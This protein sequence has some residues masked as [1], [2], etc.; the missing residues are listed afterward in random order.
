MLSSTRGTCLETISCCLDSI[1][2]STLNAF[3][4]VDPVAARIVA[5]YCDL[6]ASRGGSLGV[7]HGMPIAVKDLIDVAGFATTAGSR[8]HLGSVAH[9]DATV[10][11]RL[12]AQGALIL[13]KT[14]THEFAYGSTGDNSH[15]GAV[16]N[17]HDSARISGGSSSGSA[18]AVAA[19]LCAAALGTD[20][21]ASIRIPAALCG[22]VGMKPTYGLVPLDG[23]FELSRTLDHVG[24][25]TRDVRT[26]ALMLEV[27][28]EVP[29]A[30]TQGIGR[31][32]QGLRVGR[33]H[34]FYGAHISGAVR[35]ALARGFDVLKEAGADIVDID[36]P[37]IED[38][39]N[40][41]QLILKA[42]AFAQHQKSIGEAKSYSPEVLDRLLTGRDIPAREYIEC[43]RFRSEAVAAFDRA[44]SG[45]D[46]ILTPTAG[47]V[48]PR[49]HERR[50]TVEGVELPTFQLLTRLTAPTNFSGHPSMSVPFGRNDGLPIGLQLI[51]R[52]MGEA[53]LYQI[54]SR[55]ETAC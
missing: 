4:T 33:V 39:Y 18:A 13:G 5:T 29:G 32:V 38:I 26:N 28:A 22:V 8:Q 51:G 21:S 15:F 2:Q 6:V 14:N 45:L 30:Y 48:A 23:V 35:E 47:I 50:T 20:T 34:R 10:I 11:R 53:T 9:L 25:L 1:D 31:S 37:E 27:L 24:P 43:V 3:I 12:R 40:A 46:C 19:G 49:L 36:I 16:L 55:L 42:E 52:R 17:P 44:L 54:A 41:Q 7:L